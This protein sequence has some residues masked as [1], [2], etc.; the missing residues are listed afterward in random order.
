MMVHSKIPGMR[1]TDLLAGFPL[2][3]PVPAIEIHNIAS[4]S[5]E[6]TPGS[7][8]IALPGMRSNGIDYAIDAAK[9][10]A[11]AVIFDAADE[12]RIEREERRHL[13]FGQGV[14]FCLGAG[15]A[16]LE[17]RIALNA[18]LE[19]GRAGVADARG[20]L[21]D[22]DSLFKEQ[23]PEIR[24]T[25]A[26]ARLASDQLRL[27]LGE[28]RRSPWRLLYR[29]DQKELEFELLYDATRSYASAVSD[30]RA[31]SESLQAVSTSGR[32]ETADG[33][34]IESLLT[35]MAEAFSKYETAEQRFLQL[36]G[37]NQP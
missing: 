3:D 27:T 30:L 33:E 9:A 32:S 5:A 11:V 15:L 26:N 13:G 23:T 29:P 21:A 36:L 34:S 24:R 14:H 35:G 7:A 22:V 19:D 28:V 10:G 4:N 12:Y 1:L 16:R 18:L 31:A 6:V 25:M 2:T 8:F 17:G 37:A 20:T